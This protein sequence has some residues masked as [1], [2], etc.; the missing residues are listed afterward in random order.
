MLYPYGKKQGVICTAAKRQVSGA[1][2][3][4]LLHLFRLA[5]NPEA[6]GCSLGLAALVHLWVAN[7]PEPQ[8][9]SG[10]DLQVLHLAF[11]ILSFLPISLSCF[12]WRLP[13]PCVSCC[14]TGQTADKTSHP[15][16]VLEDGNR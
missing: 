5:G 1:V 9:N 14:Y 4:V 12:A 2:N 16:L 13:V 15:A 10:V 3:L 6:P 7:W 11:P 8:M